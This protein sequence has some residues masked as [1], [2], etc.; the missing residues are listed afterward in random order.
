MFRQTLNQFSLSSALSADAVSCSSMY[1]LLRLFSRLS[2]WF[3]TACPNLC[4]NSVGLHG[5]KRSHAQLSACSR[6]QNLLNLKIAGICP[7]LWRHHLLEHILCIKGGTRW[8]AEVFNRACPSNS[9]LSLWRSPQF[10]ILLLQT[11]KI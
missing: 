1:V 8:W 3:C 4:S 9:R 7:G 5:G 6:C 11:R 2:K 10:S